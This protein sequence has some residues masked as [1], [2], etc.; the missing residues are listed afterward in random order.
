MVNL[1]ECVSV[2]T[3][4]ITLYVNGDKVTYFHSIR[5]EHIPK[6]NQNISRQ[7][8]YYNKSSQDTAM[9]FNNVPILLIWVY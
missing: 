8:I 9:Q 4:W 3:C 5:V 6:K 2:G 1:D 7:K